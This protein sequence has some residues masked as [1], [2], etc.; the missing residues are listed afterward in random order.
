MYESEF[1]FE[2]LDEYVNNRQKCLQK[3][4]DSYKCTRDQ[5]KV[6]YIIL[7]YFGGFNKWVE[8]NNIEPF[9][10]EGNGIMIN[11]SCKSFKKELGEIGE[12]IVGHNEDICKFVQ[13]RKEQQGKD[14]YNEI[15]SVVSFYL[16]EIE[17]RILETMYQHCVSKKYVVND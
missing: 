12:K 8:S 4:M 3:V 5:A 9:D 15:G 17:N 1:E 14:D 13:Q 7:L 6:L 11:R 10:D 2:Y 16:Q